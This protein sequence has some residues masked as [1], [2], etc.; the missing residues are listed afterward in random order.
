MSTFQCII[1]NILKRAKYIG[2]LIIKAAWRTYRFNSC[3][4]SAPFIAIIQFHRRWNVTLISIITWQ[5]STHIFN[6]FAWGVASSIMCYT[7]GWRSKQNKFYVCLS[8]T[9]Y[10]VSITSKLSSLVN[11][12]FKKVR[13]LLSSS[14]S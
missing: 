9:F 4:G 1:H 10:F 3:V 12:S 11:S 13:S 2:K 6:Y 7:D 8:K 14:V 5:F